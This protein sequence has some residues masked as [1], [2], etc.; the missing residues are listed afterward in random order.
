MKLVY[1]T[2][3]SE[4]LCQ[5]NTVKVN[6]PKSPKVTCLLDDFIWALS[7]AL[8]VPQHA[9][10]QIKVYATSDTHP[11]VQQRPAQRHTPE[12]PG[13]YSWRGCWSPR[14][15]MQLAHLISAESA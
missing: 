13:R 1:F 3:R 6:M 2:P 10:H 14:K 11:Q 8:Y 15:D 12:R 5:Q 4:P 9:L 7:G